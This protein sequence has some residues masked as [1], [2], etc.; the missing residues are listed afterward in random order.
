MNEEPIF[1]RAGEALLRR[2]REEMV[3]AVLGAEDAVKLTHLGSEE[4][5]RFGV[6][7]YDMEE[8]RPDGPPHMV[9][10][11]ESE[12]Q[13]PAR[14]LALHFLLYANRKVPFSSMDAGDELL[15]L[16]AATRAV[17]GTG[18]LQVAGQPVKVHF[19]ELTRGEKIALWQSLSH[20]MQAAVYLTLEP[21]PV[22]NTRIRI[23][24]AV[25]EIR[26]DTSYREGPP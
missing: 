5:Y 19:H 4:D 3:P 10:K 7:L 11:G 20:P 6:F 16:D 9:R 14:L 23:I 15:L 22:P 25:R 26:T 8:V 24:P 13:F 12:H 21:I 2:L 1:L 17:H 18:T